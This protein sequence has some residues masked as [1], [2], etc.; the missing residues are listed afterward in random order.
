MFA[1]AFILWV[2]FVILDFALKFIRA[3]G[4]FLEC[5]KFVLNRVVNQSN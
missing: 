3:N 4:L 1:T 2:F 5:Y